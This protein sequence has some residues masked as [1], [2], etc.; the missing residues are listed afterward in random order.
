MNRDQAL[1]LV[2]D[3]VKNQNLV[4]HML[5]VEAAMRLYAQKYNEDVEVWGIAGLLHDGDWEKYPQ[6]HP[7]QIIKR[8][9]ELGADERIIHAINAHGGKDVIVPETIMDKALFA[10]DELCG[11][12]VAVARMR[13]DKLNGME[14]SSV[15][16]KLKD[17][18]FAANVR[19]EDIYHGAELLG[20]DLDQHIQA[21][22]EA[23][24]PLSAK[25]FV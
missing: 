22:I 16:R 14:A 15:K 19:R 11:F 5:C 3:W 6:E 25:L 8:L 10:C 2:T 23:I 9:K 21:I 17:K 24:Q 1:Q 20:V 13:P 7:Q 18:A 4:N 12:V